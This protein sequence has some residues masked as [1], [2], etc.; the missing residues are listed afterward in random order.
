[1][2]DL[3]ALGVATAIGACGGPQIPL[4]GGRIDATEAGPSGVPQPE[5][6][7]AT[8]LSMFSGAGFNKEDSIGLTACGHTMGG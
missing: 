7:I 6:E 4:R 1:M 3:I 2:A 8:T 5:T